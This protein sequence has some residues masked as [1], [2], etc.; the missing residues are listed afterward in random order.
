MKFIEVLLK[1]EG[2]KQIKEK[3]FNLGLNC[4]GNMKR[5]C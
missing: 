4:V 2:E 3:H 5:S 1:S